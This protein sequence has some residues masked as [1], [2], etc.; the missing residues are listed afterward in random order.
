MN[1]SAFEI[2]E[3][4]SKVLKLDFS[5]VEFAQLAETYDLSDEAVAAVSQVF[6]YL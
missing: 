6:D 2:V 4:C 5:S 3:Q 1:D